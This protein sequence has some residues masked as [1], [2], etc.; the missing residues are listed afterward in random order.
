MEGLIPMVYK[1]LRKNKARRTYECLSSGTA[2]TYKIEEFYAKDDLQDQYI[3][4]YINSSAP[5]GAQHRR[6][7]S[8]HVDSTMMVDKDEA[9]RPKPQLVRFRSHRMFSCVTGGEV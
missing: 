2:Q 7:K 6:C 4:N 8:V 1:S 3:K 5:A 9:Y